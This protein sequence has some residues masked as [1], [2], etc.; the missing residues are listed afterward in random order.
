MLIDLISYRSS[1]YIK[2]WHT[3]K[4]ESRRRLLVKHNHRWTRIIWVQW[5]WLL[6]TL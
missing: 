1:L 2:H 4:R 3:C 6:F 5:I